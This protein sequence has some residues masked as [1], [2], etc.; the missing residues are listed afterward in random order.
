MSEAQP[1]AVQLAR[2][3]FRQQAMAG[4][5]TGMNTDPAAVSH[6]LGGDLWLVLTSS[7][8]G[9]L[10]QESAPGL[11]TDELLEGVRADLNR[12]CEIIIERDRQGEGALLK[13]NTAQWFLIA[14]PGVPGWIV[15]VIRPQMM[16]L[17]ET[18]TGLPWRLIAAGQIG[19]AHV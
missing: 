14:K 9:R 5:L 16:E 17:R 4:L 10:A 1:L 3:R 12:E 19:R 7:V 6:D 8:C 2:E 15:F 18:L 11:P 13:I